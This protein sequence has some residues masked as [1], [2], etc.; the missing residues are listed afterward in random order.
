[1]LLSENAQA[2]F[3][4][5]RT[6]ASPTAALKGR[7]KVKRQPHWLSLSGSTS[8][9]LL[10]KKNGTY[11]G[12]GKAVGCRTADGFAV[13]NRGSILQVIKAGDV[14]D[15]SHFMRTFNGSGGQYKRGQTMTTYEFPKYRRPHSEGPLGRA[16]ATETVDDQMPAENLG[17][18]LGRVSKNSTGEIDHW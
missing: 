5:G 17:D 3:F 2:H 6:G 1:M 16:R 4:L 13:L 7:A 10:S 18:L 11:G 8:Q 15:P 14:T 9:R 12:Q